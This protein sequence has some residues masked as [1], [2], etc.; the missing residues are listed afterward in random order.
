MCHLPV[1]V[2]ALQVDLLVDGVPQLGP[3]WVELL[4]HSW[5][6]AA[7]YCISHLQ[8][9]HSS[10]ITP[11]SLFLS[12]VTSKPSAVPPRPATERHTHPVEAGLSAELVGPR[13]A[14]VIV[15]PEGLVERRD[16]VE[17]SL[18]ATLVTQRVLPILAALP[19]PGGQN[20]ERDIK[21]K[22]KMLHYLS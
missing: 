18:P 9:N 19:Q 5:E 12:S 14:E 21:K 7:V 6:Q 4:A 8:G 10:I 17:K 2:T 16:E 22:K 1:N 20:T 13:R 3:H 11:H 15:R